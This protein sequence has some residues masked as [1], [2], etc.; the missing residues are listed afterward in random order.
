MV[1]ELALEPNSYK[2]LKTTAYVHQTIML[3]L[4]LDNFEE[5]FPKVKVLTPTHNK[6][7]I[8]TYMFVYF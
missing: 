6:S 2:Y 5:A 4:I 7:S 3:M 1:S 8:Y